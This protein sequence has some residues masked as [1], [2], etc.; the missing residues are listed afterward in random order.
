MS[1][2]ELVKAKLLPSLTLP[3]YLQGFT[4][5]DMTPLEAVEVM[6]RAE[7]R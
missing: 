4:N 2:S 3:S 1:T 7:A 5:L 6:Q